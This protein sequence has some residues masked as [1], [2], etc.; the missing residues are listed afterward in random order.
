MADE[1]SSGNFPLR[2]GASSYARRSYG[3]QAEG[4][5][6]LRSMMSSYEGQAPLRQGASRG[7]PPWQVNLHL[8]DT[9]EYLL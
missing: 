9:N 3:G 7:R 1:G 2:Q 4:Q 5:T 6:P 8:S